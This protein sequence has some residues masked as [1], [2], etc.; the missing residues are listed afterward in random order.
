[1]VAYP[2]MGRISITYSQHG[3]SQWQH[4]LRHELSS[5]ARTL[6]SNPTPGMD[7]CFYSVFVLSCVG[8]GLATGCS[9]FLEVLPIVYKIKKLK[10]N[11]MFQRCPMLQKEHQEVMNE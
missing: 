5:P 2:H 4:R 10:K 1:M 3:R 11:R 6:G 7:V 8:S 9:P